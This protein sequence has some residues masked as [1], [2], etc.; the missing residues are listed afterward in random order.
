MGGLVI[1][2]SVLAAYVVTHLFR[3]QAPSL[4]GLLVLAL[5]CSM[6]FLGF[7]DDWSKISKE[8]SLGLTPRGKL[9]GQGAIGAAFVPA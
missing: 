6:G 8:R 9:L 7:L 2:G 5:A 1:I 3:W 4:S